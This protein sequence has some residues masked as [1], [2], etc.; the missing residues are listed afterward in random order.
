MS[1]LIEITG[2]NISRDMISSAFCVK[3]I[4]SPNGFGAPRGK[5]IDVQG[6]KA[7]KIP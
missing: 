5:S 4:A 1:M 2:K 6:M 7:E 3:G